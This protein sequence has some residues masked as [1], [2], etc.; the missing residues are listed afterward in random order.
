MKRSLQLLGLLTLIC[1]S[2][3][4]SAFYVGCVP[5]AVHEFDDRISVQCPVLTPVTNEAKSTVDY[6]NYLA[7]PKTD[8][9][10]AGRFLSIAMA[11]LLAGKIFATEVQTSVSAAPIPTC[12]IT[13]C[14]VPYIFGLLSREP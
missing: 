6:I 7:Y 14:R 5:F 3:Q 13:N 8:A 11:A 1:W 10:A 2:N 9:A 12:A 4:A